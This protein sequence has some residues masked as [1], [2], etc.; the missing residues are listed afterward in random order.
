MAWPQGVSQAAADE[1]MALQLGE[2]FG[3]GGFENKERAQAH[4]L[5]ASDPALDALT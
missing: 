1:L 2:H 4:L 3:G 5:P